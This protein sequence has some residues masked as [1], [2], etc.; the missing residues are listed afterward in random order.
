M[1]EAPRRR[2]ALLIGCGTYTDSSLAQLRSPR[3][4]VEELCRVLQEAGYGQVSAE[5]DCTA[6]AAQRAVEAF[7]VQARV[8]DALNLV[9]SPLMACRTDRASSTSHSRTRRSSI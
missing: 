5:I 8:D 4:D 2:R 6:R 3:R 7:L 1:T 9:I